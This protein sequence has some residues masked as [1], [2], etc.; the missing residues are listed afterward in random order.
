MAIDSPSETALPAS[1]DRARLELAFLLQASTS[2]TTTAC[3]IPSLKDILIFPL[4]NSHVL[5][6][7]TKGHR[8]RYIRLRFRS[9]SPFHCPIVSLI[10]KRKPKAEYVWWTAVMTS[11]IEYRDLLFIYLPCFRFVPFV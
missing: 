8:T 6:M 9:R 5:V 3:T 4:T 11:T 2:G 1:E 7:R 10:Q